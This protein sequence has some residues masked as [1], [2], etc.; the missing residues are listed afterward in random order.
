MVPETRLVDAETFA[1][2]V[3][4][5]DDAQLQR[6]FAPGSLSPHDAHLAL[7]AAGRLRG[8]AA[9]RHLAFDSEIFGAKVA[10]IVSATTTDGADL[11]ALYQSA[12]AWARDTGHRQ[13]VRSVDATRLPEAWA[14]ERTGFR[15]VDISVTLR[16]DLEPERLPA[17]EDDLTVRD[18]TPEDV[19]ILLLE[20]ATIFR[21]SYFY[22][23]PFYT[24]AGADELHRRWLIN[25]HRGGLA[26][27]ILVGTVADRPVGFIT[28]AVDRTSRTGHMALVGVH[29][30]HRGRGIARKILA[31]ALQWFRAR[32]TKVHVRTQAANRAVKI[33]ERAGFYV[34]HA[35]LTFTQW[36]TSP[37]R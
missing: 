29:A 10:R 21:N 7:L 22:Q 36:T 4:A 5:S 13:L 18:A 16:H 20:C 12:A 17:V 37:K 24:Q 6:A 32:A 31:V 23:D 2:L 26:D 15:L 8:A 11:E 28:C 34:H 33:Y 25:C 27:T 1:R 19:D 35:D 9:I 3:G 30:E 14:L